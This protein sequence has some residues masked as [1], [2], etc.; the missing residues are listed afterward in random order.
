MPVYFHE[1]RHKGTETHWTKMG[2]Q[3]YFGYKNHVKGDTKSKLTL[4]QEVT[5]APVHDSQPTDTLLEESDKGQPLY[6]DSGDWADQP[7]LQHGAL[8]A[9]RQAQPPE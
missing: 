3:N 1:K 8:R 7:D 6:G 4:T 5:P 2:G 9:N